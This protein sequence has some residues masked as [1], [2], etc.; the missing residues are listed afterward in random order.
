[1][2]GFFDSSFTGASFVSFGSSFNTPL[3]QVFSLATSSLD[4]DEVEEIDEF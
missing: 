4:E 1:M 3:S 2:V